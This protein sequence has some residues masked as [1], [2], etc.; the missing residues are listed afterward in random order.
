MFSVI[1]LALVGLVVGAPRTEVLD[2]LGMFTVTWEMNESSHLVTFTLDVKTSGWIG[3]GI[4]N[5]DGL[6]GGDFFI[7]GVYP[8]GTSYFTVSP[9]AIDYF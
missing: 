4:N 6:D 2:D 8:N 7:G 3:F 5:K 1:L 9:L